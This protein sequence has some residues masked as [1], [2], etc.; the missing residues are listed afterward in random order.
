MRYSRRDKMIQVYLRRKPRELW[1][2]FG[3]GLFPERAGQIW[4]IAGHLRRMKDIDRGQVGA[5]DLTAFSLG[6]FLVSSFLPQLTR[7]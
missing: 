4:E 3:A 5:S 1:L 2:L 6:S 7:F